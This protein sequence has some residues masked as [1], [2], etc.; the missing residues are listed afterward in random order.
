MTSN[1]SSDREIVFLNKSVQS[2]YMKDF[3]LFELRSKLTTGSI[4]P[5]VIYLMVILFQAFLAMFDN[6]IQA[7]FNANATTR[8]NMVVQEE[9]DCPEIE[10]FRDN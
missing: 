10:K 3:K 2:N 7:V 4:F 5:G 8:I 1:N 6:R 9:N